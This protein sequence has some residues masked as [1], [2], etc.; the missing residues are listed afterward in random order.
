MRLWGGC[1]FENTGH[2]KQERS[3]VVS[4]TMKLEI[5]IEKNL[6]ILNEKCIFVR[7]SDAK[8]RPTQKN[9][10]RKKMNKNHPW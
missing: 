2:R 6:F 3:A 1:F 5:I 10:R 9:V 8:K 4:E 7:P